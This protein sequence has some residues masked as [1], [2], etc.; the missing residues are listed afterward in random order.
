MRLNNIGPFSQILVLLEEEILLKEKGEMSVH[1]Q[2]HYS[3]LR[4]WFSWLGN[5]KQCAYNLNNKNI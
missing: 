5:S 2:H 4:S 3:S 1:S